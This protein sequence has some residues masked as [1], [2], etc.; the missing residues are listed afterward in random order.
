MNGK[1]LRLRQGYFLSIE[2]VQNVVH[3]FSKMDFYLW[4]E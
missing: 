1:V 2:S 4:K 3:E